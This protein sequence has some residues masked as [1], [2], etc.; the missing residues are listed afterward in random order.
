[1]WDRE[2]AEEKSKCVELYVFVASQTAPVAGR[3][4]LER[5]DALYAWSASQDCSAS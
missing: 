4:W 2:R 3:Y 1:M 5:D